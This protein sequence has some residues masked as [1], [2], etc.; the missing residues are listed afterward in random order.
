MNLF[1][2]WLG[3]RRAQVVVEGSMSHELLLDNMVF[4]GTV[5]GP[6]LWLVFYADSA[7]PILRLDFT[8]IVFA[9]D[10]NA[11][12]VYSASARQDEILADMDA[13]QWELHQWGKAN[14]VSF[15]A[16]K[17]SKHIL[18][19]SQLYGESFKLLGVQFDT[20]LTMTESVFNLAKDCRWKLKAILRTC[21]YNAGGHLI[22]LHKAQIL[23]FIEYR[24]AAI[25]H[26]CRSSLEALDRVQDKLIEAA[27]VSQTEALLAFK[28]APLAARR[29]I[30]MLGLIHRSV[31][32]RGPTHFKQ[33]FKLDAAV[34]GDRNGRHRLQ[35]IELSDRHWSDFAFPNSRPP[36]YTKNYVLGLVSI[37]NRL[38]PD[39]VESSGSVSV[40][41]G[42]LQDLLCTAAQANAPGW[43]H[44]FSPRVLWHW[45]PLRAFI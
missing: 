39:I 38:P 43:E 19:R 36:D 24:T 15:D 40:F 18:S 33:F 13:C 6:M 14:Q 30:A 45:H 1:K 10:H 12:R 35:L 11:F 16:G 32:G 20:K 7:E 5:W 17:E 22:L 44:I 25:Y 41:Q 8:G 31:L 28:L 27:G 3:V 23:S 4:Q 26:A 2:S 9:D 42:A 37:Y 21:K 29:D 34:A